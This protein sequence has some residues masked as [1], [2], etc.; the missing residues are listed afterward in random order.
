MIVI[1]TTETE[2]YCVA[3]VGLD[4]VMITRLISNSQE[5]HLPLPLSTECWNHS[6]M[7]HMWRPEQGVRF[8]GA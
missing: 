5:I 4:I 7:P 3:L 1:N 2:S 8:P 6:Y